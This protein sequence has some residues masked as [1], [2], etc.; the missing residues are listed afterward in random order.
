MQKSLSDFQ[1]VLLLLIWLVAFGIVV[2]LG[3]DA[4]ARSSGGELVEVWR[5]FVPLV[6]AGLVS[7]IVHLSNRMR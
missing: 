2:V 3:L 7:L 5:L 1:R 6:A 4:R